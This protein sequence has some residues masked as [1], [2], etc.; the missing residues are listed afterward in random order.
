MILPMALKCTMKKCIF[1]TGTEPGQNCFKKIKLISLIA[2]FGVACQDSEKE[3]KSLIDSKEIIAE[4]SKEYAP[5]K[6]VALFN[7]E[8]EEHKGK[9]VLKGESNLPEAMNSLKLKLKEKQIAYTDSIKLLP[10]EAIKETQN[11]LVKISVANLRSNPAHSAE[12]AT[13]AIMGTPLKILKKEGSWY[14]VQTPD[15]YIAW[16]DNGGLEPVTEKKFQT[17]RAAPKLIYTKAFG[18]SHKEARLDSQE[19]SDLVA[20]SVLELL[21]E[22]KHFYEVR[23]P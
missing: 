9:L 7:V 19:V 14:L 2:L 20:G 8:A 15:K 16:V 6:R 11:A 23:Y 1:P 4:V 21:G 5:D 22:Q 17:W 18:F 10:E 13:Q 3:N 12:L